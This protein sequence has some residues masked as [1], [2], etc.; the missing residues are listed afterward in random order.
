MEEKN[1]CRRNQEFCVKS[2]DV[3]EHL[4]QDVK[5]TDRYLAHILMQSIHNTET[6]SVILVA[7][8]CN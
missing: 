8:T 4:P 2:E 3:P 7:H 5:H 6:P 1:V